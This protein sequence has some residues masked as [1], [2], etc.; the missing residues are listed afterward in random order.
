VVGR[1]HGVDAATHRDESTGMTGFAVVPGARHSEAQ[2]RRFAPASPTRD[3]S[4]GR[5]LDR[6]NYL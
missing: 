2:R 6:V 4:I 5:I 3:Y 1:P